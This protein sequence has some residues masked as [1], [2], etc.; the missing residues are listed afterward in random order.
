[1]SCGGIALIAGAALILT[2]H[3]SVLPKCV[4]VCGWLLTVAHELYCQK[5]AYARISLLRIDSAGGVLGVTRDGKPQVLSLRP[6]SVVL[7]R[8]AWL[9]FCF[10]DGTTYGELLSE[11]P[12]GASGWRRMRLLYEQRQGAFG[13][14]Q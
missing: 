12:R 10:A 8:V 4:A 6:G 9:I 5:R 1:M 7:S 13:G 11:R 2:L 3:I 14:N